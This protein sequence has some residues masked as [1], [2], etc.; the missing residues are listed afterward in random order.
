MNT[1][2]PF[3]TSSAPSSISP[4]GPRQALFKSCFETLFTGQTI[5][6]G[7]KVVFNTHLQKAARQGARPGM[8]KLWEWGPRMQ[9][10]LKRI[11]SP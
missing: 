1:L 3:R 10:R 4:S 9:S 11:Q 2:S 5:G 8:S 6:G 7:P